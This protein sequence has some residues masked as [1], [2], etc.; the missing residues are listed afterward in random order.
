MASMATQSAVA[1]SV[2]RRGASAAGDS[3]NPGRHFAW[4][5]GGMAVAFLVPFVVADALGLQRDLYY[6]LY[7][8]A[9]IG[10]F[11]GWARDTGQPLRA[12]FARHWKWALALGLVF[13]GV[14][15]FIALRAEGS[16]PHPG[17]L[18]FAPAIV[19]RSRRPSA[20][21]VPDPA[22]ARRAAGQP[23]ATTGG[24][25]ARRSH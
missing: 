17:G 24:R 5:V 2:E 14:S 1:V 11:V 6:A 20:L 10:L 22:R 15:V 18:T 9:V 13:A 16:S 23:P 7:V 12:M 21:G 4:L 3:V 19:W 25:A 8:A